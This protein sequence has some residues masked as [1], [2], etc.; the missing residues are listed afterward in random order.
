M[1]TRPRQRSHQVDL[2]Q[3][4]DLD[5]ENMDTNGE[6]HLD[7]NDHQA[8]VDESSAML[9]LGTHPA[10]ITLQITLP[11][12][13]DKRGYRLPFRKA[14]TVDLRSLLD[15]LPQSTAYGERTGSK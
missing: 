2:L 8:A 4:Q 9:K 14:Q 11:N 13:A 7:T 10:T 6:T 5:D 1:T 15:Q 3:L 12:S